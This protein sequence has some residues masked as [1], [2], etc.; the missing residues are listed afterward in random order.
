M[1]A[2][3]DGE[4]CRACANRAR[5]LLETNKKVLVDMA[6]SLLSREVLDAEQ[7]KRLASGLP[8]DDPL[9]PA[10]RIP[11]AEDE[12]RPRQKE[13]SPIVPSLN[14]PIPQE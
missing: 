2:P 3:P 8:L 7:V 12:A 14:Q 9:P 1:Y 6:E 11:S 10:A 13:R 5:S 4:P